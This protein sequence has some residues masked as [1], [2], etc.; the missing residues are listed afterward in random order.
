MGEF[1]SAPVTPQ[2]REPGLD[3]SDIPYPQRPGRLP[4]MAFG[5]IFAL[6]ALAF[7]TF[8]VVSLLGHGE[9]DERAAIDAGGITL[10]HVDNANGSV[11]IEPTDADSIDIAVHVSD[12]LQDT[13][14]SWRV[15]GSMLEV[16]GHCPVLSSQWCRATY[17][18]QVPRT[19]DVDVVT[20]DGRITIFDRASAV[21]AHSANGPVELSALSGAVV[22]DSDNGRIEATGLTSPTVRVQSDNGRIELSFDGAPATVNARADNGRIDIAVPQGSGPYNVVTTS[23][24]GSRTVDVPIDTSS[25]RT[26]T[27]HSDNGSVNIHQR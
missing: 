4:W 22:A 25:T 18:I 15:D 11:R 8:N 12:G 9:H 26:I 7:G 20:D 2:E 17:T 24:N 5:S 16:R 14:V 19:I 6:A 1:V 27:A 23:S 10:V 13:G 21:T 3:R